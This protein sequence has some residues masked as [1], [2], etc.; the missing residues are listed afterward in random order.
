MVSN[1]KASQSRG[2]D[3]LHMA[4]RNYNIGELAKQETVKTTKTLREQCDEKGIGLETFTTYVGSHFSGSLISESAKG[5]DKGI[6][7][8]SED[9]V[10][11]CAGKWGSVVRI[12]QVSSCGKYALR[13]GKVLALGIGNGDFSATDA[14]SVSEFVSKLGKGELHSINY[15]FS[16]RN[17][18][19]TASGIGF[20]TRKDWQLL[21][22][23]YASLAFVSDNGKIV[24]HDMESGTNA[25]NAGR[26]VLGG[27]VSDEQAQAARE[28]L[29][30]LAKG[31]KAKGVSAKAKV[32][33]KK[34]AKK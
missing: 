32:T 7:W 21:V 11:L 15:T 33:K 19:F 18:A 2:T 1:E 26:D 9:R 13:N 16:A 3:N 17:G 34:S 24:F 27:G 22:G 6:K 31:G 14:G 28:A 5:L 30:S 12:G 4:N 25:Y 8:N 29:L 10:I 23:S 20:S